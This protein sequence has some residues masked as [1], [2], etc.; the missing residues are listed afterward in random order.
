VEVRA[1]EVANVAS[2]HDA[3]GRPDLA[4]E[5]YRSA[6]RL[7]MASG[8]RVEA[9]RM[10]RAARRAYVTL[11]GRDAAVIPEVDD[12]IL[13]TARLPIRVA[14]GAV[15]VALAVTSSLALDH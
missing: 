1:H 2:E 6:G 12:E 3:D 14:V 13:S 11:Y 7:F 15:G 8:R 4:A 10:F 5:E 9:R